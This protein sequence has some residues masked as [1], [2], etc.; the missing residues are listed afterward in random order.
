M[1]RRAEVATRAAMLISWARRV[2]VVAFAWTTE[3]RQPAARSRLNAIAASTSQA[4][5]AANDPEGR[6]ASSVLQVGDDLLDDRVAAVVGL[7]L[8]IGS[9]ESVN[10]AWW[11]QTRNS[12][13]WAFT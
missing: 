12:S 6:W 5:L 11:R 9:G 10:T 1:V 7:G 2:A 8:S 3:A 13:P 4:E